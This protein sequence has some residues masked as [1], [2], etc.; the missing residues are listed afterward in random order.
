MAALAGRLAWRASIEDTSIREVMIKKVNSE[1]SEEA[2][3]TNGNGQIVGEE[4]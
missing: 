1:R 3:S 2:I 4:E